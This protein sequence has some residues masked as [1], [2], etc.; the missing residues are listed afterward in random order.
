MSRT[1]RYTSTDFDEMDKRSR[2][3][4]INS[5]SGYKSANLVG[6]RS[7]KGQSNLALISSVFHVGANPALVGLLMRPH[8]VPRH[9]LEN[10]IDQGCFTIN[11]VSKA[12]YQRAH[13][14]AARY[15]RDQSEF[16]A[17]G[18]EEEYSDTLTAPYVLHSPVRYG[19][20]L[21][22]SHTL[23]VNETVLVVG[24]IIELLVDQALVSTDGQLD[25]NAA[26]L[27][28]ISGLDEYHVAQS[29]GRLAYPKA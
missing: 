5:L 29:L 11:T 16:P 13:Q 14:T 3:N 19:L 2:T 8:T 21:V 17:V 10:M 1:A 9:S 23:A 27:V 25:L 20:K 15:P 4:L 18:F 26:E 7:A 22:E 6:T 24:Q 28:A 12:M